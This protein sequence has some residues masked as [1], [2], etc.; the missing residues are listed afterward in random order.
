[1]RTAWARKKSVATTEYSPA[2]LRCTKHSNVPGA[3]THV[4]KLEFVSILVHQGACPSLKIQVDA[5]SILAHSD[6]RKNW[7]EEIHWTQK[8]IA[9]SLRKHY[10]SQW[11]VPR[12]K[13]GSGRL[14][15]PRAIGPANFIRC[16]SFWWTGKKQY[17]RSQPIKFDL[18]YGW[19]PR[20]PWPTPIKE[21]A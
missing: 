5:G 11:C 16:G 10:E 13:R 2:F 15:D 20:K 12:R 19:D 8:N 6:R 9:E 3:E 14:R 18:L 1:M 4:D 7:F 17:G 21:S